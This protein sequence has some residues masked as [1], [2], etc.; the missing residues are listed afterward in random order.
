MIW[1][2]LTISI[3]AFCAGLFGAIG[4]ATGFALVTLLSDYRYALIHH[5]INCED[6]LRSIP[7]SKSAN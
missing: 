6:S 3:A 1:L 7:P 4:F 5:A 2:L